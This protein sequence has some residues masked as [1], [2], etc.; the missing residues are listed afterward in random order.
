MTKPFR[1][2]IEE[3]YFLADA[4]SGESPSEDAADRFH[5]VAAGLFDPVSHELLK[6]Q[7]EVQTEPGTSFDEARAKLA[8]LRRDLANIAEDHDLC[9]FAAGSHPLAKSRDQVTT[10]KKRYRNLES[11]VGIMARRTIVCAMHIHVEVCETD[12]RIELMNRLVP[13]LPLFYALSVSSPFWQGR[14]AGIKGFRLAAFSEWPRMG[15]PEIFA[16]QAEYQHFV[17]LLVEAGVI[18]DASFVWWYMRPSMHYPT[19][20]LRVCDSCTRV[21][22]AVAI[23]ALYQALVRAV[24]RRPDINDGVGPV[25]RGVCAENIWQVQRHGAEAR[26]IDVGGGG[27]AP[28]RERLESVL[29]LIGEDTDALG[30]SGWVAKTRDILERGTSADRQLAAFR[31]VKDSGRSHEDAMRAVIRMLA[32]ETLL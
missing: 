11:E 8:G 17:R 13:F 28:V 4:A 10:D 14:N 25:D 30:S 22:D 20:E 24:A 2:G 26:L 5:D 7:V 31:G 27:V 3:E 21:D 19:I 1:F 23:A 12:R 9:L 6:G 29:D 15:V 32:D 18:R 16:S